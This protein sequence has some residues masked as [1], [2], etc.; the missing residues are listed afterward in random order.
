MGTR[1][2]TSAFLILDPLPSLPERLSWPDRFL[3][4]R[5]QLS[6][7]TG[8]NMF[9]AFLTFR[10]TAIYLRPQGH[11][12]VQCMEVRREGRKG[13]VQRPF[14]LA[15]G[16]KQDLPDP[17]DGRE[18]EAPSGARAPRS[19]EVHQVDDPEPRTWSLGWN[20]A[21]KAW[22]APSGSRERLG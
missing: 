6:Y 11:H 3:C 4:R 12:P 17:V 21:S 1:C 15:R 18:D 22:S 19:S 16:L 2:P 10:N 7:L 14:S 8:E 5:R 9:G 13:I 20:P